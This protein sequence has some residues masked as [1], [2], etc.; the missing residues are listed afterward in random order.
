[1]GR[2]WV[3]PLNVFVLIIGVFLCAVGAILIVFAY[4]KR[5]SIIRAAR[6]DA[7]TIFNQNRKKANKLIVLALKKQQEIVNDAEQLAI[8]IR[9]EIH[10]LKTADKEL[11]MRLE[12]SKKIIENIIDKSYAYAACTELISEEDL[13]SNHVYKE[14]R[15]IIKAK[16]KK[17]AV[18]SIDGVKSF[19]SE[20]NIANFVSIS[21]KANMAGALLL[22]TVEMLSA[23]VTAYNGHRALE[24][25]SESI[26]ATE[27]LIKCIDSRA[28][29]YEEFKNLL[30]KRLE[31]EIHFKRAKQFAREKQRE[32]SELERE[33]RY[34]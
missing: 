7:D 11:T 15:K 29:I 21:A 18:N 25:L 31:I 3:Y 2:G 19:N 9:E 27:T 34:I 1:M 33:D 14:D 28:E 26:I 4:K 20:K 24:K 32:L 10:S 8:P 30:I 22:T 6:I 17:L 23:K 13:V 16:L 5:I 12:Q